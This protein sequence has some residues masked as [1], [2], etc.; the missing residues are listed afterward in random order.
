MTKTI[1]FRLNTMV[2]L[3]MPKATAVWLVENTALTFKQIAQFCNLHELEVQGIADD[4]IAKGIVAADPIASGQL[5]REEIDLCEKDP[6]RS[7][8]LADEI[9][10]Y[11]KHDEKKKKSAPYI[12]I[13]RRD[14]KPNAILWLL[15]NCPEI[16]HTQIAKL[17]GTTKKTIESVNDKTHW[18]IQNIKP[19]DPVLLGLCLQSS[20]DRVHEA[21]QKKFQQE[22]GN[23]ATQESNFFEGGKND[24]V[25]SGIDIFNNS[26]SGNKSEEKD[27]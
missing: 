8:K 20:L 19:Q 14:D 2:N 12:P 15:K 17:I 16:T 9:A 3:L 22:N 7:L 18:N 5:T 25:S 1:L 21:A 4:E 26:S 24:I 13:A 10:K 27:V 11:L 23:A 6:N